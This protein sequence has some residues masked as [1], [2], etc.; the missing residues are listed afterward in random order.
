MAQTLVQEGLNIQKQIQ[1]LVA[2]ISALKTQINDGTI[3]AAQADALI[4]QNLQTAKTIAFNT[5]TFRTSVAVANDPELKALFDGLFSRVN[6]AETELEQLQK[7]VRFRGVVKKKLT[8]SEVQQRFKDLQAIFA[9]LNKQVAVAEDRCARGFKTESDAAFNALLQSGF[10]GLNSSLLTLS[11]EA[12][13]AGL[14]NIASQIETFNI[15]T[16]SQSIIKLDE[17]KRRCS[18]RLETPKEPGLGDLAT[19]F[20][21]LQA[22]AE[23]ASNNCDLDPSNKVAALDSMELVARGYEDLGKTIIELRKS[24]QADKNTT[25]D[26]QLQTIAQQARQAVEDLKVAANRC[27]ESGITQPSVQGLQGEEENLRA[28]AALQDAYNAKLKDDWRVRITLAPM[29]DGYLYKVPPEQ[30]GILAPLQETDGVIFPYTP[31]ISVSYAA[32]YDSPNPTHSN[33]LFPQYQSSA[34]EQ[35]SV[36]GDFTAQDTKEANYLLA[37]IHFFRTATKMFYGQDENPKPGVPPPILYLYGLGAYQFDNHPMV[38]TSFQYQL[39]ND[40]DYIRATSFVTTPPGV[41]KSPLNPVNNT[42]AVSDSRLQSNGN[43]ISRNGLA[44]PANFSQLPQGT[45]QPTYVPTRIRIQLSFLPIVSRYDISQ[46]FSFRDYATG[47][48]L[49]GS[50]NYTGGIW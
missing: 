30:A 40:V 3:T 39:P 27:R 26:L 49:Q 43:R 17:A 35:I 15:S 41:N 47:K 7:Q 36:L 46:K 19:T 38:L 14:T 29:A 44:S 32:K 22:Q 24:A 4:K 25:L 11:R 21:N 1:K 5:N 10:P 12:R 31:E 42:R 23:I 16:V 9:A 28:Q 6:T 34:V 45:V 33:Y 50:K 20:Q 18:R 48:L 2:A 8:E 37:V 13:E